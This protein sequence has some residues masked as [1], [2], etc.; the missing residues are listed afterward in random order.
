MDVGNPKSV[1]IDFVGIIVSGTI[2][3][4]LRQILQKKVYPTFVSHID[5]EF[6]VFSFSRQLWK[7]T[8]HASMTLFELVVIFNSD[9]LGDVLTGEDELWNYANG[10]IPP[11]P[12]RVLFI[13]QIGYFSVD[14]IYLVLVEKPSDM[15]VMQAHHISSL[16]LLWL[17]YSPNSHLWKAGTVFL[18]LHDVADVFI[19]GAKSFHYA[20][21]EITAVVLFVST[22]IVWILTRWIWFMSLVITAYKRPDIFDRWQ[23]IPCFL[24]LPI[25]Y[26]LHIMWGSKMIYVLYENAVQGKKLQDSTDENIER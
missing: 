8:W 6:K 23:M 14:Y 20:D 11:L 21:F 3:Q 12:I 19:S 5:D 17:A 10:L 1:A 24:L 26:F 16:L 15:R 7:F 18:F 25:L 9:F 2:L 4:C 13:C 22:I